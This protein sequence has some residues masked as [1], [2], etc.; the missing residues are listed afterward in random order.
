MVSILSAEMKHKWNRKPPF[1]A[2]VDADLLIRAGHCVSEEETRYYLQGV[3]VEPHANGGARLVATDGRKMVII[4]DPH[5]LVKNGTGIVSLKKRF[6][7]TIERR[8]SHKGYLKVVIYGQRCALMSFK[9]KSLSD[10]Q[11][12]YAFEAVRHPNENVIAI[13]EEDSLIYGAYPDYMKVIPKT[14]DASAAILPFD[15]SILACVVKALAPIEH[16]VSTH[17]TCSGDDS[18]ML[19][20]MRDSEIDGFGLIMPM[21]GERI[22][23]LPDWCAPPED[24]PVGEKAEPADKAA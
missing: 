3:H 12:R 23:T 4:R 16:G 19:V 22:T 15:T 9:D 5:A 17:I 21:R 8:L 13:Q 2:I 10:D 18:P 6:R 1:R 20:R 11:M 7:K 24:E 14:F